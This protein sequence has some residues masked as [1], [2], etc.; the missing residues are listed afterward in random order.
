[1]IFQQSGRYPS[2]TAFI[3]SGGRLEIGSIYQLGI[4]AIVLDEGGVVWEGKKSYESLEGLLNEAE[5]GIKLWI[6]NH[7]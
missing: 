6:D 4:S 5:N 3:E 7:G 1:M 2:L